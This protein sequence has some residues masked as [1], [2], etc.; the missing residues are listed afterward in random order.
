M[1]GAV[2]AAVE[3]WI[4]RETGVPYFG[5]CYGLHMAVID[6]ARH[7]CGLDDANSTEIDPC[8]STAADTAGTSVW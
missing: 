2:R 4:A 6:F 7:V 8:A 5:L 1:D 3:E